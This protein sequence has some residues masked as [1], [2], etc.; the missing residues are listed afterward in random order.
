MTPENTA[1]TVGCKRLLG[2]MSTESPRTDAA[3]LAIVEK[4]VEIARHVAEDSQ[5]QNNLPTV[6]NTMIGAVLHQ[7]P[8][9]H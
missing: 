2:G 1:R 4:D 6:M 5:Q 7:L 3:P 8:Q 9:C